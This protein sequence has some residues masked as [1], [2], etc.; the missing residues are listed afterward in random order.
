MKD[1]IAILILS[2]LEVYECLRLTSNV[3]TG[4]YK[5][6]SYGGKSGVIV[7]ASPIQYHVLECQQGQSCHF[8]I[9]QQQGEGLKVS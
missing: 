9:P 6:T 2:T 3:K 7:T 1:L 4:L 8:S 5:G